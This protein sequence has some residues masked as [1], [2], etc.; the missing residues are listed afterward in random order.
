MAEQVSSACVSGERVSK[1]VPDA[2]RISVERYPWCAIRETSSETDLLALEDPT[3]PRALSDGVLSPTAPLVPRLN[4]QSFSPTTLPHISSR[5]VCSLRPLC[6]ARN[7]RCVCIFR[8][9][10]KVHP[11]VA[12]SSHEVVP[13]AN[14]TYRCVCRFRLPCRMHAEASPRRRVGVDTPLPTFCWRM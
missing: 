10:C 9:P 8:M 5:C 1:R 4:F 14:D 3:T 2:Q 11:E 13:P 12:Q 6:P 7:H